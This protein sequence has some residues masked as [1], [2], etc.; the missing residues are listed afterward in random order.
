MNMGT[1]L[2]AMARVDEARARFQKTEEGLQA[3][4]NDLQTRAAESQDT[5]A[6]EQASHEQ[7]VKELSERA[8]SAAA[9]LEAERERFQKREEE[10][11]SL[12]SEPFMHAAWYASP[13]RSHASLFS[14]PVKSLWHL[15]HRVC[16]SS[17][18]TT[19]RQS[20]VA[21]PIGPQY[22]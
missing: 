16:L 8:Q 7:Q 17:A 13:Q 4:L 6:K 20:L 15:M 5:A 14:L 3:Q 9:E 2:H 10:L 18:V 1:T 12:H 11:H 21:C 22:G 19:S